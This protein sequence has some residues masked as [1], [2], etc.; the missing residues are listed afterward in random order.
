M[1]PVSFLQPRNPRPREGLGGTTQLPAP[2]D[3]ALCADQAPRSSH[4]WA[5]SLGTAAPRPARSNLHHLLPPKRETGLH[6]NTNESCVMKTWKSSW[7]TQGLESSSLREGLVRPALC[8]VGGCVYTVPSTLR[9]SPSCPFQP[10]AGPDVRQ[11]KQSLDQE[12]EVRAR[13]AL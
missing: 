10:D 6:L 5:E 3:K 13:P 4:R 9:P 2:Q 8:H 12:R 7:G 11:P 1:A